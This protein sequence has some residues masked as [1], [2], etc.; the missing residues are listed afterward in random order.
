MNAMKH[1]LLQERNE[2]LVSYNMNKPL[3]HSAQGEGMSQK[4]VCIVLFIQTLQD[5]QIKGDIQLVSD[6]LQDMGWVTYE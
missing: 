1:S 6:C 3:K 2:T 4:H 5:K